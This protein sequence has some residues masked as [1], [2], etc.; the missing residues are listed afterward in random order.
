MTESGIMFKLRRARNL[1]ILRTLPPC[2]EI[3]KIVSASLD[4]PL[5]FKERFLMRLHLVACKPCVRYLEQSKFLGTAVHELDE[6][7]K[8]DLFTGR[9][10]DTA[11]EN[12]KNILK[13]SSA[14]LIAVIPFI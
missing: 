1:L 4:R 13:A 12:L 8:D 2:K 3:V 7:L 6:K 14:M 5:T 9:L 10:S 11:R